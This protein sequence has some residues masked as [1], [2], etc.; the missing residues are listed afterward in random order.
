ME[1]LQDLDQNAGMVDPTGRLL[2]KQPVLS[3][4]VLASQRRAQAEKMKADAKSLLEEAA[5]LEKEADQLYPVK[6]NV[7]RKTKKTKVES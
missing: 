7:V 2:A 5:R 4:E 1:K 3:D 6:A